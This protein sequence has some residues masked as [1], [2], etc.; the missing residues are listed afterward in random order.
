MK[1]PILITGCA[2]SG[3]SMVAG[4]INLCGAFGGTMSGPNHNNAK[5]MFENNEIRQN[6]VKPFLRDIGADPLGQYPLPDIENLLVPVNWQH[7]VESIMQSQGLKED[8]TWMY[9][10]AK[11]CLMWPV[12]FHAFPDAKWIIV[13][14]KTSDIVNSCMRT[15]FMKAFGQKH[16]QKAVGVD[17]EEDGW[18]W[19][20]REHE[21]RFMEMIMNG[22][23]VKMVWPE[24]MV[25][26]NYG[27][28]Q[29]MLEWLNLEWTDEIFDFIE[30][31]LWKARRKFNPKE[32]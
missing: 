13:R 14:R 3:T 1:A 27:Q 18:K 10:G 6:L 21:K 9:K 19:W 2:R 8:M 24:R 15:G 31:K 29:E 11:M 16:I 23:N 32:V 12:W 17:T 4:I 5:G 25:E 22:L 7:R 26:R 30:P 28:T 20:V